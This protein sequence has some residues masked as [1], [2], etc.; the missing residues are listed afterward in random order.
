MPAP[1]APPKL[2][3]IQQNDEFTLV[4]PGAAAPNVPTARELATVFRILG[5]QYTTH[6]LHVFPE[7]HFQVLVATVLS[8]RT[9]DPA[10]NE[11]MARL[12]QRAGGDGHEVRPE[13]LLAIPEKELAALL[14]PVGFYFTKAKH[15]HALCTALLERFDGAVPRTR[16][17]LLELPGVGRKVANLVLNICF[18]TAAICVDVHVHRIVNR[19]GWIVSKDPLDTEH[20]L[21]A[22]L[23]EKYWSPTNLVLVNHGQQVCQPIVPQCSRCAIYKHC[24][25]V[26]VLKNR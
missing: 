10:T 5:A 2:P 7:Q 25:R 9:R 18:D 26:N 11:A 20:K 24:A 14:R 17:E 21:M 15:L 6:P 4:N 12:W 19:L 22:L 3:P 8:A 16:D 1:Q 13:H 23:P